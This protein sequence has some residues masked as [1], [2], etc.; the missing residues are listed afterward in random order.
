[1]AELKTYSISTDIT[2]QAVSAKLLDAEIIASASV[3]NY[4]GCTVN[5]DVL[6]IKG[7]SIANE[8]ILDSTVLAHVAVPLA[9]YKDI[10][11]EEI[12]ARTEEL[13]TDT[14]FVFDSKTFSL[15][16]NA[17]RNFDRQLDEEPKYSFPIDISTKDN[18]TYSLAVN[19]NANFWIAM[20]DGVNT[21]LDSG[22]VLKKSIFDAVDKAAVDAIEDTR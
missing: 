21:H 6:K 4:S 1:M 7:D 15:S 10:R 9:A 18:D 8:T 5:G 3:T 19:D 22:R 2:D 17:Q 14:G 11:H 13:I 20:K 16:G 12:D